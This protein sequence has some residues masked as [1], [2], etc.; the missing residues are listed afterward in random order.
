M[1]LKI[2]IHKFIKTLVT[3]SMLFGLTVSSWATDFS[4]TEMLA[5]QGD[6]KAQNQL[7]KMY[8][9]GEGV[10]EDYSKAFEWFY[11]SAHQGYSGA[12]YNLGQMYLDG[13]GV[14]QNEVEAFRWFMKSAVQ[15]DDEAQF[16]VGALYRDGRGV[17][18]DYSEA[19]KWFQKAAKQQNAYAQSEIGNLYL[20]GYGVDMDYTTAIK[21]FDK[22]CKNGSDSGCIGYQ[23]VGDPN[24]TKVLESWDNLVKELRGL[25]QP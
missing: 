23:V 25:D 4:S 12:Q 15:A 10:S 6:L 21:W 13:I 17:S 5:M 9:T 24:Y 8:V 11:S 16:T 3:L 1:Y 22:A 7:G 18:Q 20:K 2:L 19:M 14:T